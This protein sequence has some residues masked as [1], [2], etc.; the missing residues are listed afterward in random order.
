MP[1]TAHPSP[2]LA[3]RPE[4][5]AKPLISNLASRL[6]TLMGLLIAALMLTGCT[7][8]G[9]N[10]M[11][12]S[13]V[14]ASSDT[15]G[16]PTR[17]RPSIKVAVLLPL[18]AEGN[19]KKIAEAMKRAGELA[20]FDFKN[21][22]LQL[23]T[24]DTRGTPEGAK[25][26]AEQAVQ[27]GAE[28]IIGPLFAE[29]VQGAA[30]VARKAGV[31]VIAFSSNRKV[32]GNGVYLL[33]FLA[34]S[35][36]RRIVSYAMTQG[37]RRFA[38]LIPENAFGKI[39]QE[40]FETAV[41]DTGGQ[42][43]A[44]Q[45]YKPDA[46]SMLKPVEQVAALAKKGSEQPPQFDALFMPG[47][48]D[49]LPALAPLL[50]YF[51]VDTASIQILGSN[52]WDYTG[53]G[54]EKPLR[55][56]WFPAADPSGWQDFTKRYVET[57][58]DPPPRLASLAYDAVSLAATLSEGSKGNRYTADRLTRD[59]GFSGVDGLFR[60]RDNGLSQRGLAILE[61]Q[62]FGANVVDPAPRTFAGAQF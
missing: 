25:V 61:V 34:G 1:A 13:Q 42:I 57:Y 4:V 12:G 36:V 18:S 40:A 28:L 59:S 38:A 48:S 47:S 15:T 53:I 27:E 17:K 60:L 58:G 16:S 32:A 14:T 30:P 56:A 33:S 11:P 37:H 8:G 6:S 44:L 46:N 31:P 43:V 55:G 35:E 45:T 9:P 22:E 52:G 29:A 21:P 5:N 10:S 26:A 2:G 51:E 50:P 19:T 49:T 62:R 41:R 54:R 39:M 20:L 3:P 24:K 23:M 7:V